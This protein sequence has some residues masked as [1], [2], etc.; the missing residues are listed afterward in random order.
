MLIAEWA[1]AARHA[2]LA[3][4]RAATGVDLEDGASGLMRWLQFFLIEKALYEIRYELDNRPGWLDVPLA[5]LRS[6]VV[7]ST[8]AASRASASTVSASLVSASA[9]T[10]VVPFGSE[11]VETSK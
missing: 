9:Q 6:L 7:A 1:A 11:T 10:L 5:G 4:Y 3:G 2:F 8:T